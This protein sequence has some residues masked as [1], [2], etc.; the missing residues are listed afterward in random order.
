MLDLHVSLAGVVIA[1]SQHL[2]A[3][4]SL[5]S[6]WLRES[7]IK[8]MI[9]V[10]PARFIFGKLF[11]FYHIKTTIPRFSSGSTTDNSGGIH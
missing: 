1:P 10:V 11:C 3:V 6:L 7:S 8:V 5:P 9:Y 4:V 2:H